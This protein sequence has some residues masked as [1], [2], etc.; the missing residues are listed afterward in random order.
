MPDIAILRQPCGPLIDA[1]AAVVE[2]VDRLRDQAAHLVQH[3]RDRLQKHTHHVRGHGENMP[4]IRG[5]RWDA[6]A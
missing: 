2:W 6:H 3:L 1:R 4:D 5:W